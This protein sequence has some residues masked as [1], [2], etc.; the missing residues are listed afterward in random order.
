ML[1]VSA[2]DTSND[3]KNRHHLLSPKFGGHN[4]ET[5]NLHKIPTDVHDHYN[6]V[7]HGGCAPAV[8]LMC[9]NLLRGLE[10]GKKIVRPEAV[11]QVLEV[12]TPLN[13]QNSYMPEVIAPSVKERSLEGQEA[14]GVADK[15]FNVI[16]HEEFLIRRTLRRMLQSQKGHEKN[17]AL[18][19]FMA[20]LEAEEPLEAIHTYASRNEFCGNIIAQTRAS[21]LH[22]TATESSVRRT[23]KREQDLAQVLIRHRERL[24][25]VQQAWYP[26]NKYPAFLQ[27]AIDSKYDQ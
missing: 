11:E 4:T 20:F 22:I 2:L 9:Q 10:H 8:R 18:M 24:L 21:I 26:L 19:R 27:Q 3:R 25:G 5:H 6:E 16:D 23:R 15:W 17:T 7:T 14:F 13:W 1:T 12:C